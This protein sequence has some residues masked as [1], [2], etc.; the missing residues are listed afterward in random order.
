VYKWAVNNATQGFVFK[1]GQFKAQALP[2]ATQ[3]YAKT[4]SGY[5]LQPDYEVWPKPGEPNPTYTLGLFAWQFEYGDVVDFIIYNDDLAEEHPWHMHGY[6]F[7]VLGHGRGKF[8]PSKDHARLNM[9]NPVCRDTTQVLPDTW[10]YIRV[11]FDNPGA[12]MFHCHMDWH[13]ELGLG[14]MMMVKNGQMASQ[15]MSKPETLEDYRM[16]NSLVSSDWNPDGY[17]KFGTGGWTGLDKK[18]PGDATAKWREFG[19]LPTHDSMVP[20]GVKDALKQSPPPPHQ[21]RGRRHRRR[22]HHG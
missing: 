18:A 8:D 21:S 10:A 3:F 9:R 13:L 14:A 2:V 22:G 6:C 5:N 11:H 17:P 4:V 15:R 20:S 1:R 16:C 19:S 7:H 12:W